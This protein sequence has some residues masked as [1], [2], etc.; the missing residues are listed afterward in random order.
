MQ[1]SQKKNMHA[2]L[3]DKNG[4]KRRNR[5]AKEFKRPYKIFW[6]NTQSSSYPRSLGYIQTESTHRPP[7]VCVQSICI[8]ENLSSVTSSELDMMKS[9]TW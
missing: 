6:Q 9:L 7:F 2:T 1:N 3:L 5:L 8:I 4:P